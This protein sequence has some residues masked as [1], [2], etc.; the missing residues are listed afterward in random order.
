MRR[1]RFGG[2]ARRLGR[3]AG[4]DRIT[5]EGLGLVEARARDEGLGG[6]LEV[7]HGDG[8]EPAAPRDRRRVRRRAEQRD[9]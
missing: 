6:A 8:L 7:G 1:R 9:I 4:L 2:G 3:A 5:G